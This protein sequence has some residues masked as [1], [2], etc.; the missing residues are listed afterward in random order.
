MFWVDTLRQAIQSV[1]KSSTSSSQSNPS[2]HVSP[3]FTCSYAGLTEHFS[4]LVKSGVITRTLLKRLLY[5]QFATENVKVLGV[6]IRRSHKVECVIFPTQLSF[7]VF[8]SSKNWIK[9]QTIELDSTSTSTDDH[10]RVIRRQKA[11][12]RCDSSC[13][14]ECF[15]F[16]KCFPANPD[17]QDC[18][19]LTEVGECQMN[20]LQGLHQQSGGSSFD[21]PT[22]PI[23]YRACEDLSALEIVDIFGDKGKSRRKSLP[24]FINYCERQLSSFDRSASLDLISTMK[25]PTK[26]NDPEATSGA[27][28]SFVQSSSEKSSEHLSSVCLKTTYVCALTKSLEESVQKSLRSSQPNLNLSNSGP[29]L[30]QTRGLSSYGHPSYNDVSGSP[31]SSDSGLADVTGTSTSLL[32]NHVQDCDHWNSRSDSFYDPPNKI[33]IVQVPITPNGFESH[34]GSCYFNTCSGGSGHT[35]KNSA[36]TSSAVC[37]TPSTS[38]SVLDNS[39]S[40]HWTQGNDVYRSGM[41][42]HWWLKTRIPLEVLDEDSSKKLIK[43][44][45]GV[46][47]LYYSFYSNLRKTHGLDFV[48]G[49]D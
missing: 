9:S 33:S 7:G 45:D 44:K 11:L 24:L 1:R 20:V 30:R 3:L 37:Y 48:R 42:A 19:E 41:Y 35:Y 8:R 38:L 21:C 4:K 23:T 22:I 46:P 2:P 43:G 28:K 32:T 15:E 18:E 16:I 29:Y 26:P 49:F 40:S 39:H 17:S 13:E 10:S 5:R 27:S 31:R 36:A 6:K 12:D 25:F 34:C 14:S 47:R